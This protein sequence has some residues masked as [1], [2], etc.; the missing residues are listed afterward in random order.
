MHCAEF[1]C[2]EYGQVL[3]REKEAKAKEGLSREEKI[4]AFLDAHDVWTEYV[5]TKILLIW[6]EQ[7]EDASISVM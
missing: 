5:A 3:E 1:H 4:R 7:R 6:Q 2:E